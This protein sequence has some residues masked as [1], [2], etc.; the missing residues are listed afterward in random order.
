MEIEFKYKFSS[1]LI[2]FKLIEEHKEIWMDICNIDYEHPKIFFILL[3]NAIDKFIEEG[4]TKF[5]Q[6]ILKEEWNDLKNYGWVIKENTPELPYLIIECN[7]EEAMINI[8]GGL[9]FASVE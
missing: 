6:T 1:N 3:R 8:A 4:Y 5:V 7:I 9:G 2:K